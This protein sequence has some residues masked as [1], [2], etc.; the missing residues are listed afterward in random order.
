MKDRSEKIYRCLF[1]PES[2][3]VVGASNDPLK[4]GGRVFKNIKDNGYQG[5]LWAVNP[6]TPSI[7]GM[8]AFKTVKEL[9][10]APDLALIAI[11]GPFV[12]P[13]LEDLARK[14]TGASMILTAGFGE[15]DE[16]GKEEEK[17]FLEI[18]D[19]A[20]MT[21]IGPNCS[22]FLTPSYAGKFAGIIPKVKQGAVDF[23]SGSGATVDYLMEQ[24]TLRGLSFSNVLNVGNSIQMGVEDVLAFLDEGFGPESARI[25]LLYMELV[26]KPAKLLTHA[27]NLTRKGCTLVGIKS[28]VTAAGERAAASHTGAMAKPDTAV[29]ALFDKAGIIRVRS[30]MELIDAACVLTASRGPVRGGRVCVVT[31]AGGP[32]VMLSDEL[33][34]QGLELPLMGEKARGRLSELLPPESAV[35]NPID[36]LPGRNAAQVR[37]IFRI[38]EEEEAENIDVITMNTGNSGLS[39]NRDLYREISEAMDRCSI[40]VIPVL[41][42][43]TTCAHLIEEFREQGKVYFPD[44]VA[45]GEALGRVVQR[46]LIHEERPRPERYDRERIE[47]VLG[48]AGVSPAPEAVKEILT[49]AGFSL[50]R[51]EDVFSRQD[52]SAACEKVGFPLV[53][54]VIGPLHKSD[55]GG[56]RVGIREMG[57][58]ESA[59]S[60]LLRIQGAAGVL[61][62][63]RVAGTEVIL[64]ARREED[65]GHLIM[66]GLGGIYTEALR[67]VSFALAP[68]GRE[69]SAGMIRKVRSLLILEG[70]RGERGVSLDLLSEYLVRLSLLVTDFPRI[71]EVDLNPVKG[72]GSELYVVDARMI[73][74]A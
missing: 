73:L 53:M 72:F 8:P 68:L 74:E 4:P 13:A 23:V 34:R 18:A 45:L 40:P 47:A 39:D 32:G 62:Q 57:Q 19:R 64:G 43:G 3:V 20:G 65:F 70:V 49:A 56:V 54:K 26:K 1:Q 28:G 9:P 22:G 7:M 41:S 51:Q 30:K 14:G 59:W 12:R 61:V 55:V 44:E 50:P 2:I 42:S 60:E 35:S 33:N 27:G 48:N 5:D 31:D 29:Q 15:K 17:R 6:K 67:D 69:E 52:L 16:K 21:L 38:I 58:A 46:P 24:A 10:G 66:F 11:P 36:C 25:I 63:Q 37:E 71:E